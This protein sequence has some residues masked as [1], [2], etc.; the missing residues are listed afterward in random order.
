M[1]RSPTTSCRFRCTSSR[2]TEQYVA[3]LDGYPPKFAAG[4]RFSYCNGGFVVLA[5]IAERASGTPFH[6]LVAQRV[7]DPAGMR[8]TA[9]LRS[10]ELP[11][12]TALGYLDADG[13]R[14]NVLHL[15]VRGSG[16]GGIYTT[17]A[18]VRALW[19]A[20]LGGQIVSSEWVARDGAAAKRR[21][22]ALEA[23]RPGLLAARVDG[24]G[25]PRGLRRR[26]V[27]SVAPRSANRHDVHGHLQLDRRRLADHRVSRGAPRPR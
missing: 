9:F 16:D 15:P 13:L 17:A 25:D 11:G 1:A 2:R 14:T 5:L 12:G 22:G 18:D 23:L 24:H 3:V 10:D 8:D 4:E 21:T 7:C 26:R 27:V 6:E 20:F 19:T